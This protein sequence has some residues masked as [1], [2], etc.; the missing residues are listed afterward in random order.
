MK[1]SY[2]KIDFT[3]SPL[4]PEIFKFLSSRT[5]ENLEHLP[6]TLKNN[7]SK[8]IRIL[9]LGCGLAVD[10]SALQTFFN[11][12]NIDIEYVAVDI[13]KK[14]VNYAKSIYK[15]FSNTKFHC[16]DA[17]NPDHLNFL[18]QENIDLAILQHLYLLDDEPATQNA[19]INIITKT[20][21]TYLTSN[22]YLYA[23]FYYKDEIDLFKDLTINGKAIF[24]GR[25]DIVIT[26]TE[27]HIS[28]DSKTFIPERF[29]WITQTPLQ[30]D[31]ETKATQNSSAGYCW[32]ALFVTTGA[33]ITA[34]AI[35]HL[36]HTP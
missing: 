4:R 9:S 23:S 13:D 16:L 33:V 11:M 10:F 31:Q 30:L 27:G 5:L 20:V 3:A 32:A 2:D 12:L 35:H 17:S 15:N 24:R 8:K 19:C 14:A 28:Q 25:K 21:P 22:G 26:E 7:S 6:N 18:N 1:Q 29:V 34:A 36:T